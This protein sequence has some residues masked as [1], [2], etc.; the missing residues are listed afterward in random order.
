MNIE[1]LVVGLGG[2]SASGKTTVTEAL[3]EALGRDALVLTHD[4]YYKDV[5]DPASFNYDEPEAFDTSLMVSHIERLCMRQ[6][7]HLPVYHFPTHARLPRT[8]R[9]EPARVLLVEGI[10]VLSDPALRERMDV[11]VFVDTPLDICLIR[12]IRRDVVSRGWNVSQV[13]E[14]YERDVRPGYHR[15]IQPCAEHADLVIKGTE[16]VPSLVALLLREI[17]VRLTRSE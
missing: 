7:A 4:R 15:Y 13:L 11:A 3:R 2:A 6:P 16:P 14:R 17:R 1:P 12:R 10:L 5:A 9:V 8:E